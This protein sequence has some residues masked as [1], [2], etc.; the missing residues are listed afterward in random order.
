MTKRH[1]GFGIAFLLVI[2]LIG[3]LTFII[4]WQ[5]V[6][7]VVG[8]NKIGHQEPLLA[9]IKLLEQQNI[10][11]NRLKSKDEL[12]QQNTINYQVDNSVMIDEA[13]LYNEPKFAN[14]LLA[15]VES[16]GHLIYVLSN[17]RD[18]LLLDDN[19][20]LSQLGIEVK[21]SDVPMVTN[22]VISEP[23]AN[24]ILETELHEIQTYLPYRHYFESCQGQIHNE[25]D[26]QHNLICDV[27][28]GEGF[29]TFL[30]GIDAF[31]NQGL[32][33]LDHGALLLW[34]VGKNKALNYL[35]SFNSR[36][37]LSS[38][39]QWSWQFIVLAISLLLFIVWHLSLRIG[40]AK[41]PFYESQ[42]PFNRHINAVGHFMFRQGHA[43][44]IH[45]VLLDDIEQLMMKRNPIFGQL[46][47]PDKIDLLSQ[48]SKFE[49]QVIEQLYAEPVAQQ[50][51][52]YVQMIKL[53][54]ALKES[55]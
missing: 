50:N 26:Y 35:P 31:S 37:W 3:Y 38:L 2:A 15:W 32:K 39:W 53:F 11:F 25:K 48:L 42:S 4:K 44:H 43:Q 29:I 16:G 47:V 34:L 28:Y 1:F 40:L 52:Q 8:L 13:V 45:K 51:E 21:K 19:A 54:K 10:N 30:P 7:Q 9:S 49:Q 5:Q 18:S 22:S 55:L 46:T 33:N 6:E 14:Q 36:G 17:N 23:A 41:S 24:L 12:I 20:I 27:N